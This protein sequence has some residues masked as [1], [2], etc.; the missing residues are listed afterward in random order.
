MGAL[1]RALKH[2]DT[3]LSEDPAHFE[4]WHC[5]A[6]ILLCSSQWKAAEERYRRALALNPDSAWSHCNL[7]LALQ[8]Q[9]SMAAC[10][11]EFRIA[12]SLSV[13]TAAFHT[14]FVDFLIATHRYREAERHLRE[15]IEGNS[16]SVAL[17]EE[18][19]RY[20]LG[21]GR[22]AEAI[23]LINSTTPAGPT[24]HG[25]GILGDCH[26]HLGQLHSSAVAYAQAVKLE[27]RNAS[28]RLRLARQYLNLKCADKARSI[29]E[30]LIL[31][32]PLDPETNGI[33]GC[34]QLELGQD[35][36]ASIHLKSAIKSS[37]DNP[38][39]L[40]GLLKVAIRQ[41]NLEQSVELLW[42][43]CKS[44]WVWSGTAYIE[45]RRHYESAAFE[46]AQFAFQATIKAFPGCG[47]ARV[48]LALTLAH[49]GS[50]SKALKVLEDLFIADPSFS[51]ANDSLNLKESSPGECLPA[52]LQHQAP[53]GPD[54]MIIGFM[55]CGTSALYSYLCKHPCVLPALRKEVH[56]FD[57]F[58]QRSR[59]WYEFHFPF[60]PPH[61][62][63][64]CAS[65]IYADRQ[66]EWDHVPQRISDMYPDL[67]L[68]VLLRNPVERAISHFFHARA[69]GVESRSLNTALME[70]LEMLESR[71]RIDERNLFETRGNQGYLE[72]GLYYFSLQPWLC[73]FSANQF[74][75]VIFEEFVADPASC[76]ERTQRF[77]GLSPVLPLSYPA[78]GGFPREP[79]NL[80][81]R[82]RVEEFFRP[83]NR[84]LAQLLKLSLPW[85]SN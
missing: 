75:F 74:H 17:R 32:D 40:E 19:G 59:Q 84:S 72:T 11:Q 36:Q 1:D 46:Q 12:L 49:I 54:F 34:A 50:Y 28:L 27:P 26:Q 31:I 76:V 45:G 7:G 24:S 63:S 71:P 4:A 3:I 43:L 14:I 30:E 33:L 2:Y 62:L 79:L 25:W 21:A 6:D 37:P 8:R 16:A 77:L 68:I 69:F 57:Y 55:R 56:Y 48:M 82:A 61:V 52:L 20:L 13:E 22:Y 67:K 70:E 41:K 23:V 66:R 73:S 29:C 5:S 35:L 78:E 80:E 60:R 10:E 65:P 47:A 51:F 64:G 42:K 85:S 38:H 15:C 18:L 83:Y 9:D 44:D 81:V 58:P 53:R 39:L